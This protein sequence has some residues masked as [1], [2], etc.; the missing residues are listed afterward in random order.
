MS[1]FNKEEYLN[2]IKNQGEKFVAEQKKILGTFGEL[3]GNV[4]ENQY[5]FMESFFSRK[6][7]TIDTDAG[8]GITR[9]VSYSD[10]NDLDTLIAA[11]KNRAEDFDYQ[12][13]QLDPTV[14]Y[15]TNTSGVIITG[16]MLRNVFNVASTSDDSAIPDDHYFFLHYDSNGNFNLYNI[17]PSWP[18][19]DDAPDHVRLTCNSIPLSNATDASELYTELNTTATTSYDSLTVK[20]HIYDLANNE[21]TT[22]EDVDDLSMCNLYN[23]TDSKYSTIPKLTVLASEIKEIVEQINVVSSNDDVI[24]KDDDGNFIAERL[25]ELDARYKNIL[26]PSEGILETE[27]LKFD[28]ENMIYIGLLLGVTAATFI[29]ISSISGNEI[30]F[31]END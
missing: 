2:F 4:D 6:L 31:S 30:S 9:D 7:Q 25:S 22:Q 23:S 15:S 19:S 11:F 18:L 24:L 3:Q 20:G 14:D 16:R 5:S 13:N 8:N 27:G 1:N 17:G 28:S 26:N 10:V 12:M 21:Y 29:G